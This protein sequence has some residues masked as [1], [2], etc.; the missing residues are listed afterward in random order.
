[1]AARVAMKFEDGHCVNFGIGIPTLIP[2]HLPDGMYVVLYFEKGILGVGPYS[3]REDVDAD[4][5]NAGKETATTLSKVVFFSSS[6]SFVIIRG[7]HLD[8]AV[9][10]TMQVSVTDELANWMIPRARW[11]RVWAA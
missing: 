7:G 4:L 6:S 11:S 5:I 1:M 2:N 8:I 3:R 10:G 9:F